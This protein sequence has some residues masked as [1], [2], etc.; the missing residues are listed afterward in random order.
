MIDFWLE[1]FFPVCTTFLIYA[2]TKLRNNFKYDAIVS[3]NFERMDTKTYKLPFATPP[4][5]A[6]QIINTENR[7]VH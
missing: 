7:H 6:F 3:Y 5:G 1:V 2:P 4:F